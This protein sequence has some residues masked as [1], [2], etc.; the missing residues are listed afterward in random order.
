[1][2]IRGRG[3]EPPYIDGFEI[4]IY[5][6]DSS[7]AYTFSF[8]EHQCEKFGEIKMSTIGYE[9]V[10]VLRGLAQALQDLNIFPKSAVD[11]ELKASKIHLRDMRLIVAHKL[12]VPLGKQ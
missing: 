6:R 8:Q 3:V 11:A 12:N 1:M 5:D 4:S 7:K 2:R 10:E 9:Q